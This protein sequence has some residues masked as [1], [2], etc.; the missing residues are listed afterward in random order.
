[1]HQ[2]PTLLSLVL[3]IVAFLPSPLLQANDRQTMSG[4]DIMNQ[5]YQRHEQ[6]PYVYEEQSMILID[7]S[8]NRDTRQLRRYSRV[9]GDSHSEGKYLL[10][11]D[12]PPEVRGVGLLTRKKVGEEPQADIYLPAYGPKFINS[13]GQNDN[14]NFLGTDFSINDLLPESLDRYRYVRRDDKLFE[15]TQHMVLDVFPKDSDVA[16]A[17]PVKTHYVRAD[18]FYITRSDSYDQHGRLHKRQTRHDLKPLGGHM[19]R[20]DMILM[21][22]FKTQ[23][24]SLLKISRRI[25]SRDY[26]P[27]E[28]FTLPWLIKNQQYQKTLDSEVE[29]TPLDKDVSVI[30]QTSKG[31]KH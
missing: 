19:W 21:E 22:D 28:V 7:K 3:G 5:V 23:H 17:N 18:I 6:F 13:I 15:Y 1:M 14:G 9:E 25:F 31:D 11:F 2:L 24:Q 12:D 20:A 4:R 8:G 16:T 10:L 26:V 29:T 30:E 27:A